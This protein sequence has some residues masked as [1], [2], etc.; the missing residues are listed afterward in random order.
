MPLGMIDTQAIRRRWKDVGSKLDERRRRRAGFRQILVAVP[1]A[2]NAAE[3]NFPFAK[4]SI[5]VLTDIGD[6]GDF[7]VIFK[8]RH[9]LACQ[10][11]N[12]RAI[13]GNIRNRAYVNESGASFRLY[14]AIQRALLKT[15]RAYAA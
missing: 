3:H 13:F 15:S 2:G 10:T 6:G 11:N 8:N 5:L 14:F 9:P 1:G 4:R 12:A 7:S